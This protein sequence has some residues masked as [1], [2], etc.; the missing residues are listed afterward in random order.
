MTAA[1]EPTLESGLLSPDVFRD[2]GHHQVFEAMRRDDP[3]HWHVDS[4]GLEFW[5]LTKHADVQWVSRDPVT[6]VSG[7]GFTL[8]DID[9]NDL[10]G[11]TMRQMLP[12]M[13]RPEHTRFRRVVGK[14]FSPRTLR[15]VEDHLELKARTIVDNIIER[16]SCD[17]VV[18]VAAELP[19]QAIA[20]LVGVPEADRRRIFEWGNAMTGIDDPEFGGDREAS[21][22]ASANMMQ[23]AQELRRQR[24]VDPRTTSSPFSPERPRVRTA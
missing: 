19:L 16:G 23:Y 24:M 6:F 5:C 8:V 4:A 7:A 9:P 15:L 17:F 10:Q 11:S 13:D 18:D 2:E 1:P 22:A 21:M 12:G 3:V 20:E 14:G